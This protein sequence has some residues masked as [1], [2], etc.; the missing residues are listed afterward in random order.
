MANIKEKDLTDL[1]TWNMKELR[2]LKINIKNRLESLNSFRNSNKELQKNNIL[3]GKE[4]GELQT[5]LTHIAK[6]EKKLAE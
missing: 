5:L 2:K 3:F 6:A 4:S 1:S